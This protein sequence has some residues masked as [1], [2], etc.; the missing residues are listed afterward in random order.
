M[1]RV[2]MPETIKR[3]FLLDMVRFIFSLEQSLA[4]NRTFP[5][6]T[7]NVFPVLCLKETKY[8]KYVWM[9]RKKIYFFK[10]QR[11]YTFVVNKRPKILLGNNI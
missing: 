9:Y 6:K 4:S 3:R 11:L 5:L 8:L 1:M 10:S 2:V 7:V